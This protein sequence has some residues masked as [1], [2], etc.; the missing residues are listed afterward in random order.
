[1]KILMAFFISVCSFANHPSYDPVN[2]IEID[3]KYKVESTFSGNTVGNDSFHLIIAKN[4]DTKDYDVIPYLFKD[5]HIVKLKTFSFDKQPVILSFHNAKDKLS[6][7]TQSKVGS[8]E[9]INIID[10]DLISGNYVKSDNIATE[11]F[12]A[13]IRK[14]DKNL[15]VF[16]DK[17][18]VRIIEAK[19]ANTVQT[20]TVSSDASSAEFLASLSENSVEAINNDEFVS[21]GS[22]STFRAYSDGDK[23]II[24]EE[25]T[26]EATTNALQIPLN[27]GNE[28]S[29]QFKTF[30]GKTKDS[31]IKKSTSY[32]N[33]D[34]LYQLKIGKEEGQLNVFG[35][36]DAYN[37]SVNILEV[38]PTKHAEGFKSIKD[39]VKN[40]SKKFNEPT[41]TI[42]S[43]KNGKLKVR[44]DFVNKN[45]YNYHYN[46]WWH[47]QW[48]MQQ[49]QHFQ[50]IN[51]QQMRNSIPSF[52]PSE[53]L[54]YFFVAQEHSFFEITLDLAGKIVED[55]NDE[56]V[57][58]YLNKKTY[59]KPLNDNKKLKHTSTV[60]TQDNFRY[61]AYDKRNKSF[62]IINKA[63]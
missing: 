28:V 56:S 61:I 31:K 19:D 16:S 55:K 18:S 1:M 21:N 23:V 36:N 32:I 45:L 20:I 10:V 51:Q 52:G 11:D 22:I 48:H 46:W 54:D 49:M 17:K 14:K 29:A 42:N 43:T 60:F 2:K 3:E 7:L 53:P 26:K 6:L 59:V 38:K 30:G 63:L 25:N 4:G 50:M 41:V 5:N 40:A 27:Q 35:L 15:I 24:T 12:K 58:P 9:F 62:N 57:Y 37:S 8:S 34:K 44:F 33:N 47:H 13:L 39:F